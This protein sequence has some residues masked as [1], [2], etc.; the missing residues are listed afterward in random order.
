MC[1]VSEGFRLCTC[2][3]GEPFDWVLQ[4]RD[5]S[6]PLQGRRGRV[7]RSKVPDDVLTTS[8]ALLEGLNREGGAFDFE[9]T[10]E[11]GDI[12]VVTLAGHT[13]RFAWRKPFLRAGR[14]GWDESNGLTGW[15]SQMVD[16]TVGR[17]EPKLG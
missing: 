11:A 14:W 1:D 15:R 2:E 10:P 13:H 5:R 17:V 7:I 6:L 8:A 12:L 3:P 16:Q 4:R 9:Y